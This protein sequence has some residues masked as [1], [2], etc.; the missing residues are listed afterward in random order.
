M[1]PEHTLQSS[2]GAFYYPVRDR[3]SVHSPNGPGTHY[4][5]HQTVLKLTELILPLTPNFWD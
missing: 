5:D 2:T 3:V 1:I 4:V